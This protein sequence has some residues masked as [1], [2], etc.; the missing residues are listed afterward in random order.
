MVDV[1]ALIRAKMIDGLAPS[2][3][4]SPRQRIGR[5]LAS[6]IFH[7]GFLDREF[8][9]HLHAAIRAGY[10]KQGEL[11]WVEIA[12]LDGEGKGPRSK[13]RRWFADPITRALMA[14]IDGRAWPETV[15][16]KECVADFFA[17]QMPPEAL[18]DRL[19]EIAEG[20]WRGLMPPMLVEH[21]LGRTGAVPVDEENWNRLLRNDL[22]QAQNPSPTEILSD[23][24][25][26][27]PKAEEQGNAAK[28]KLVDNRNAEENGPGGDAN[29]DG[30]TKHSRRSGRPTRSPNF[31]IIIGNWGL[32]DVPNILAGAG[33]YGPSEK[34]KRARLLR[35]A[36]EKI[37]GRPSTR[38]AEL[39]LRG[40]AFN[41]L[42]FPN[43][44]KPGFEP[45]TFRDYLAY[46][47]RDVIRP[48]DQISDY[49]PKQWLELLDDRLSSIEQ[50]GRRREALKAVRSLLRYLE[51]RGGQA[52]DWSPVFDA[53]D[54]H[55]IDECSSAHL[56]SPREFQSALA[57]C[58]T[59]DQQLS[60]VLGYRAGLRFSEISGLTVHDFSDCGDGLFLTVQANDHRNLKTLTSRRVL[61]LHLLLIAPELRQIRQRLKTLKRRSRLES[62]NSRLIVDETLARKNGKS[63]SFEA[64]IDQILQD[65]I[66]PTI[67]FGHLRHCFGSYLLATM[68][69]P[70]SNDDS[71]VPEELSPVI[72][73]D[74]QSKLEK[75]L[76]GSEKLGQHG[77]HAVSQSMGHLPSSTTL[78]WY[79]H[80][81]DLSLVQ[82]TSRASEMVAFP[83]NTA[84]QLLERPRMRPVDCDRERARAPTKRRRQ[85]YTRPKFTPERHHAKG[86]WVGIS[87]ADFGRSLQ[88]K[89]RRRE[90]DRQV[91]RR[92]LTRRSVKFLDGTVDDD[93]RDI[94]AA[95]TDDDDRV[96][97][98]YSSSKVQVWRKA[99]KEVLSLK[100]QS[101]AQRFSSSNVDI[102]NSAKWV[103]F[104][105]GR[106]RRDLKLTA[107]KREVLFDALKGWDDARSVVRFRSR[108]K[109]VLYRDLL[110]RDL[111]FE[112]GNIEIQLTG[113]RFAG[114]YTSETLHK[115][116]GKGSHLPGTAARRGSRGSIVIGLTGVNPEIDSRQVRTAGL[117]VLIMHAIR[118]GFS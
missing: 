98:L 23:E 89:E 18:L 101:G 51:K 96:S 21:A 2:M 8:F 117:F 3:G 65:S 12:P 118:E 59:A 82:Y 63:P 108:P 14:Q 95:L 1:S 90:I 69:L 26:R 52:N 9:E 64:R 113:L 85:T 33:C 81:L 55:E 73:H 77:L 62:G 45:S 29:T 79:S 57:A 115:I 49:V 71:L 22:W 41:A 112:E 46:L 74:R 78:K 37:R 44:G 20:R 39:L 76:L 111:G 68:L 17:L 56:I 66:A 102:P 88:R 116:L 99:Y 105:D 43:R 6:A 84:E 7:G 4:L 60:L 114:R 93:W 27:R 72:S 109:A 107:P 31:D 67:S 40:W 24:N 53:L 5:I 11:V 110:V 104:V 50:L 32:S 80:L 34:R 106:W 35:A 92:R 42:T 100:K 28:G 75:A 97:A 10:R 16:A 30:D 54:F 19:F 103:A 70:R 87:I 25:L 13:G 38:P 91:D 94:L 15:N 48:D 61:P 58:T 36:A 47:C 83:R 86:E